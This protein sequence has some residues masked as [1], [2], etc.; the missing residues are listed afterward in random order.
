MP[1][2]DDRSISAFG[3]GAVSAVCFQRKIPDL[4]KGIPAPSYWHNGKKTALAGGL[5][6]RVAALDHISRQRITID[7][8]DASRWGKKLSPELAAIA[9]FREARHLAQPSASGTSRKEQ[10]ALAKL[11]ALIDDHEAFQKLHMCYQSAGYLLAADI[12][13]RNKKPADA[14]QFLRSWHDVSIDRDYAVDEAFGLTAVA[15]LIC[16]GA[17]ADKHHLSLEECHEIAAK[18]IRD[19]TVRLCKPEP[20]KPPTWNYKL[21]VSYGQFHL[22]PLK[23]NEDNVYFQA[24]GES[25]QGFSSFPQQVAFGTPGDYHDCFVEVEF[26]K[27]MPA[28]G[29]AAQAVVVP[30]LVESKQGL[31]LRTVDDSGK[32]HR[33]DIE[34]GR[35]DVMARFFRLKSKKASGSDSW[36]AVLTFLPSGTSKAKCQ[37]CATGK[38]PRSVVLHQ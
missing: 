19:V 5:R 1:D 11:I 37:K 26:A 15:R 16:R 35:Y 30:L 2:P 23:G 20:K 27:K 36:R 33:L 10:Q 4:S 8:W 18:L 9:R 31:Y 29:T 13:A 25:E 32:K 24:P 34:P 22:E 6:K 7:A 17:L 3:D 14:I 21:Y 28:V 38:A 12:A